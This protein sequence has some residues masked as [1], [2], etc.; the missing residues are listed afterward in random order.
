M[1]TVDQLK[2]S[3]YE[4]KLKKKRY[5]NRMKQVEKAYRKAYDM[6]DN[7]S[8]IK[9]NVD[10]CVSELSGGLRGITCT[11]TKCTLISQHNETLVLSSQ[12]EFST[13]IQLMSK[14]INRCN[15]IVG[16]ESRKMTKYETEIKEQG[17]VILPW[18]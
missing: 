17:G 2:V 3:R 9:S 15:D 7:C 16:E 4:A 12:S 10:K 6:D 11:A 14:E 1:A 13:A 8:R 18:E 5:Q